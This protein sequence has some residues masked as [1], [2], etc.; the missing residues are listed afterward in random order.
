M[1]LHLPQIR[2]A[3]EREEEGKE[4]AHRWGFSVV[5]DEDGCFCL[6]H[7]E[8]RVILL[9]LSVVGV[10]LI[11]ALLIAKYG[12]NKLDMDDIQANMYN[13]GV[14]VAGIFAG[15]ACFLSAVHIQQHQRHFLHAASQRHLLWVLGMVPV[16]SV[17][18]FLGLVALK[19]GGDWSMY[20]DFVR[21]VYEAL[22]IYQFFILLTK[23]LG[24]SDGVIAFLHRKAPAEYPWPLNKC[25][26]AR[27]C[28]ANLLRFMKRGALQYA[29][30]APLTALC[31]MMF[32]QMGLYED[33]DLAPHNAYFWCSLSINFS[34]LWALYCLVWFFQL[35][36]AELAPFK[37][38]VKF[39][40]VK[41]VVF[42][43][44]WQGIALAI[45]VKYSLISDNRADNMSVGQVQVA[46]SNTLITIEMFIAAIAVWFCIWAA[47]L[48]CCLIFACSDVSCIC[49]SVGL[50]FRFNSTSMHFRGKCMP[51]ALCNS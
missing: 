31:A 21:V 24:G 12:L 7:N 9:F 5:R 10:I 35:M 1:Q 22:V 51:T 33:G 14:T 30:V 27:V 6:I 16:Y 34:Q 29:C 45:G 42:F 3:I 44:F 13:E 48:Q 36:S 50:F 18:S 47:I 2:L 8:M 19:T 11:G 43:T 17:A 41:L 15:M 38:M 46:I 39:L 40:V 20:I 26:A 32:R 37:P 23:Y 4:V 49:I 28:D 25:F